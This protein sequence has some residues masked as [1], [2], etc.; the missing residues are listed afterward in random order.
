MPLPTHT[1][2]AKINLLDPLKQD[3]IFSLEYRLRKPV[4]TVS[5]DNMILYRGAAQLLILHRRVV[6]LFILYR[7]AAQMV[8]NVPAR[9]PFCAGM[10]H[11]C[12]KIYRWCYNLSLLS[13]FSLVP[14]IWYL[15]TVPIS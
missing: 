9:K 11:K 6:Q 14:Y 8:Q 10:L 12:I 13:V 2:A 4:K 5:H 1:H 15:E 3:P 7:Y